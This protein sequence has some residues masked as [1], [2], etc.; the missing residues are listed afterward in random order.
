MSWTQWITQIKKFGQDN[1]A[2]LRALNIHWSNSG[3]INTK[4]QR[5]TAL[6]EAYA[7]EGTP[8]LGVA[9]KYYIGGQGPRT[10]VI[11]N[12]LIAEARKS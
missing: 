11:A 5:A 12:A 6:Q 10:L 4:A 9:G 3:A 8:A 2:N 7:V 1:R